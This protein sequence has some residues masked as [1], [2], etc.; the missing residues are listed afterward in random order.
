MPAIATK[1]EQKGAKVV[2]QGSSSASWVTPLLG[3]LLFG[4][5]LGLCAPGI[6]QWYI[7]WLGLV[8]LL[9]LAIGSGNIW[10][11]FLRGTAFG[12]AY[13]LVYQN[14]YLGLQPLDWL[15][16]N[17]WQGWLLAVAAW[18]IVS[19]HQGLIVG[20]F[21]AVLRVLPLAGTMLPHKMQGKWHLP[22]L[23]VVPIAWV[24]ITNKLGNAHI[25]LG[26]PW[27]MLEYSQY[28][29][30]VLIQVCSI[31]GGIGLGCL[32]A[33]FNTAL[34]ILVA[35]YTRHRQLKSLSAPNKTIAVLQLVS[36]ALVLTVVM[37]FGFSELSSLH[38]RGTQTV[39][40]IQSNTNIE[41]QKT[42]KRMRLPDILG[43]LARM[44]SRS[45]HTGGL[46]ILSESAV[47]TYL[48]NE[49]AVIQ[50]LTRQARLYR[51][52]MV[53]GAM[54]S[55]A[56]GKAYNSAYGI[57]ADGV[58]VPAV[59]HKRY[60]VPFGEYTPLLVQYFPQWIKRLTNTPAGRGFEAGRQAHV[61]PLK[62]GTV[63]PL[64]CFETI[65]PELVSASVRKGGELLV[66]ISD[67]AWFHK[68]ICGQQMI[69]CSVL[70]AV[71]NRRYFVFA[72]NTGPSAII[73]PQGRIR[74][75]SVEGR[76]QVI[77]GKIGF[78]RQITP[79]S[80]LRIF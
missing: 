50:F 1:G 67:L 53:V 31:I 5:L 77:L 28:K 29:Q 56:R 62:S 64:I 76:E 11:A 18:F 63:A 68:S 17:F 70:R 12:T 6:N 51:Q 20:I 32:I 10:Q 79:F 4:S 80:R 7:A 2:K 60:L 45:G 74:K 69:A 75:L 25:A 47:P 38:F 23:I 33:L 15:G 66:N 35:T 37:L 54:D 22:A 34:A 39:S 14:W 27:S 3:S 42:G 72:A 16:F 24:L 19:L 36:V 49:P 43:Q 71:E 44:L 55:D 65:S 13:N 46:S 8:P 9:I 78:V 59:Y 61:L 26:V 30:T 21:S 40:I 48:R 52:D 58:L 41:M 73:D 57:T